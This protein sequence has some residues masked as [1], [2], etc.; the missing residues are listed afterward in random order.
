MLLF[1]SAPVNAAA[2]DWQIHR[3]DKFNIISDL[4]VE[5][6]NQLIEQINLFDD[7]A[8]R[9]ISQPGTALEPNTP[10]L[11]LLIFKRRRQFSEL[12]N[13]RHFA[14]FTQPG[15][16][17]TLLVIGPSA[18]SSR[19]LEN[20]LHEYTHYL[21]R[22][23][24]V[25][26]P[27]WYEEGLATMLG[28]SKFDKAKPIVKIGWFPG[29]R[30]P[31]QRPDNGIGLQTLVNTKELNGWHIKRM[32]Q[33]YLQSAELVHFFLFG[34]DRNYPDYRVQLQNYFNHRDDDIFTTLGVSSKTLARQWRRYLG[35]RNVPYRTASATS[36][37]HPA[38]QSTH[39]SAD[40][41]KAWHARA[42]EIFNPAKAASL[43]AEL[44][45][46]NPSV[47]KHHIDQSRAL[48][49]V[50]L[51]QAAAALERASLH[52]PDDA[53]LLVQR[54]TLLTAQ[55]SMYKDLTC[56]DEWREASRLLRRALAADPSRHDAILQLGITELYTGNPGRAINYLRIAYNRAPWSPKI[57]LHMG[58]C[59][60]LLGSSQA[61]LHLEQA[62]D[63]AYSETVRQLANT[64]LSAVHRPNSTIEN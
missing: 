35:A 48:L 8:Q 1:L 38:V 33:F 60:R 58:E 56:L 7:V 3:T 20:S 4:P 41:S 25:S 16:A 30:P 9:Y 55:C 13:R 51:E 22:T 45:A 2:T 49:E 50:D 47:I 28:R 12:V 37:H 5:Q 34:P 59:L 17:D 44:A 39:L 43:Y 6:A 24:A 63:W 53:G 40:E 52:G 10:S 61:E 64:A 19:V 36:P 46:S 11:N 54:A 62:R 14:A 26:Y 29:H 23:Q 42:A 18:G 15:L 31:P 27:I 57:N 32:S 21:L